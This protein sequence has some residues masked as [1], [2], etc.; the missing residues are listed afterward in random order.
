[1]VPPRVDG[2]GRATRF[3]STTN[4]GG[5]FR[6]MIHDPGGSGMS[7]DNAAERRIAEVGRRADAA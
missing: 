3:V 4:G 2:F 6:Q 1:M 5:G 7:I